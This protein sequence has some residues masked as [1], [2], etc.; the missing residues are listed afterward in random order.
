MDKHRHTRT[1]VIG[2][3]DAGGG[4]KLG[5]YA[6]YG[7]P[8]G[9]VCLRPRRILEGKSTVHVSWGKNWDTAKARALKAI[10]DGLA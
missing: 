2:V 3:I 10:K 1:E 4:G 9:A 6:A 7:C 8:C 5:G